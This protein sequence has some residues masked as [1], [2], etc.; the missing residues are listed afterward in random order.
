[1][2]RLNVQCLELNCDMDFDTQDG[3][4]SQLDAQLDLFL[5]QIIEQEDLC[6][7]PRDVSSPHL[8]N[9]PWSRCVHQHPYSQ[10]PITTAQGVPLVNNPDLTALSTALPQAVS[11]NSQPTP[12]SLG[13]CYTPPICSRGVE[14]EL[15]VLQLAAPL[16]SQAT[17]AAFQPPLNDLLQPS[18]LSTTLHE[19]TPAGIEPQQASYQPQAA[20]L[21]S[22]IPSGANLH[23]RTTNSA[24]GANKRSHAWSEKNRRAQQRFRDKQKA[25]IFLFA[26][27]RP[28]YN[29]FG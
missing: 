15:P 10:P 13:L 20:V 5:Q 28:N 25:C 9:D 1:M 7:S 29:A 12:Q 17:L 4:D 6:D 23:T 19:A 24:G 27:S 22:A 21:P 11:V 3:S 14:T 18:T 2:Q 16:H 8:T 26:T